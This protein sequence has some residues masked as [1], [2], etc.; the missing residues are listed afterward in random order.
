M[1]RF[2]AQRLARLTVA[3]AA[4]ALMAIPLAAPRTSLAIETADILSARVV[5]EMCKIECQ[6]C[7]IHS[8]IA[9]TAVPDHG[10]HPGQQDQE[11]HVFEDGCEGL[12]TC[13]VD[14]EQQ[15]VESTS[16]RR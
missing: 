16:T 14:R 4:A 13:E 10:S 9:Q 1:T 12:G 11:C 3:A 5:G 7:P 2:R 6:E 15:L 8:Q